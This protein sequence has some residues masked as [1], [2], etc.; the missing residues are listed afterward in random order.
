ML[1]GTHKQIKKGIK[2]NVALHTAPK[3]FFKTNPP[4][5]QRELE[6]FIQKASSMGFKAVQIGP[7][8][9][10]VTL[11]GERLKNVLD[12][13]S[14]LRSVH[15]G[16]LYD[17][18]KFALAEEER[19]KMQEQIRYGIKLSKEISSTLVSI[20]PPFFAVGKSIDQEIRLEARRC[21][22]QLIRKEADFANRNGIKMALESFCYYPF[23][24]EDLHDFVQF[25][26][27][28]PSHK[29]GV[30][31]DLGHLYQARISLPEAVG[32]FKDKLLDMHVHDATLEQD[33][34]KATH[35]PIGKGEMDFQEIINILREAGYDG[36]LTLEIRGSEKE[37]AESKGYLEKLILKER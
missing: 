31:L 12:N 13:F 35:L 11:D 26:S 17:A 1:S 5:S 8:D 32:L 22:L 14:M 19:T 24:F 34:R 30:L 4:Y 7:L 16:G 20:H 36:W 15:V 18:E 25:V 37:I 28:F 23:I 21:F 9:S 29:L 6:N 2:M 33:F 3:E 27:T 10:F